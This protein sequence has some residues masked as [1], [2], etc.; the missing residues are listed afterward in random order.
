[1]YLWPRNLA[2][3]GGLTDPAK[4]QICP[5]VQRMLKCVNRAGSN[6]SSAARILPLML[7]LFLLACGG[8]PSSSHISPPPPPPAGPPPTPR[9]GFVSAF[10]FGMQ[11]GIGTTTNCK[12][13]TGINWP[14]TQAQPGVLRLHDTGTSWASL[15]P[16]VAGS[17]QW[18]VLDEWLDT[19]EMHSVAVIQ[20]FS[21]VPC[22][23][24]VDTSTCTKPTVS[25]NGTNSPPSDLTAS[26]S[27][28]FNDF[29]T[30]FI[31]HCSPAGNCV[32]KYIK[33]Y[34]MWNEW[35]L[36]AHWTGT[37]DQL[38]QMLAPAAGIIRQNVPQAVIL[39]PS[40]TASAQS[41]LQAWLNLENA[42][43]RIS[44]WVDWHAYLIDNSLP[45]TP[46]D[47]WT[48]SSG[49]FLSLLAANPPWDKAPWANTETNFDPMTFACSYT[50]DDCT[51]QIVRWQI[52]HDSWGAS[53]LDWYKWNQ[54]IGSNLQNPQYE[55]AYSNAMQYTVGGHYTSA[56]SFTAANGASTWTAPFVEA[57]GTSALWVW[58]PK[59]SGTPYTVPSGYVDYL[60]LTGAKTSVTAGQTINIGP[61]P[62]LLEQ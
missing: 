16:T 57:N 62:F 8:S 6:V 30:A 40:V 51:G 53:T 52:L 27:P 18:G 28:T 38:Y 47:K 24:T 19:I 46:E 9:P 7:L 11:C 15:E 23:D 54:T 43:G 36:A 60:D 61:E 21:W 2:Q 45:I 56:A 48:V 37:A 29:V 55:T 49:A 4:L 12:G 41:E 44:D 33:Y 39:T 3:S 17:Y 35:D 13:A 5:G 31:T 10:S 25:P 59:E 14:A 50:A 34:E 20:V 58:T 22:W 42:N 26:G 32:S 1:M